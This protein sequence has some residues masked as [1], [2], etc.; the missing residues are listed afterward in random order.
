[1][2]AKLKAY[3]NSNPLLCRIEEEK[4]GEKEN[5]LAKWIDLLQILWPMFGALSE[6]GN[7]CLDIDR[8]KE[9]ETEVR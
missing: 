4:V 6:A 1:M 7:H 9:K 5:I 2:L 3:L 8:K